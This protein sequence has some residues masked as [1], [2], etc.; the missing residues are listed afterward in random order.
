MFLCKIGRDGG[1]SKEVSIIMSKIDIRK[2]IK[3][4]LRIMRISIPELARRVQCNQQTL[5]NYL[6]GNS[7]LRADL[8]QK[9]FNEL[10][11]IVG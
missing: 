7:E 5:Y 4:K 10:K 3:V 2:I 8:M 9:V 6:A 1:K 11:I